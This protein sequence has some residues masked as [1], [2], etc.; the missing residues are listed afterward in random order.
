MENMEILKIAV[1]VLVCLFL[2]KFIW[3]MAK[4]VVKLVL[5]AVLVV[6]GTYIYDREIIYNMF[7]QDRTEQMVSKTKDT[8]KKGVD[9]S[10]NDLKEIVKDST[11]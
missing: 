8:I 11:K 9:Y 3:G 1:I 5:V 4:G 2:I 7:G 6:V 10:K